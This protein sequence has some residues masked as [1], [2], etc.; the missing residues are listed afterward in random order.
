MPVVSLSQVV[1]ESKDVQ[2]SAPMPL[3]RSARVYISRMRAMVSPFRLS[4]LLLLLAACS[5]T[6]LT[7]PKADAAAD[8]SAIGADALAAL[9]LP[10]VSATQ[11]DGMHIVLPEAKMD[12]VGGPEVDRLACTSTLSGHDPKRTDPARAPW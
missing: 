6:T 3:L 10:D 7:H 1:P 5:K 9:A 4:V 11:A 8:A 2:R 12:A